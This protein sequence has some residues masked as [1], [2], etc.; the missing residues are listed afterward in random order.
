MKTIKKLMYLIFASVLSIGSIGC[1][2]NVFSSLFE[3]SN[4]SLMMLA[5]GGGGGPAA[6][7]SITSTSTNGS[8]G[9]G[10]AINVTV[11]FSRRVTLS[12]G[13]LDVTLDTGD[14]V[15]VSAPSYPARAL[16]GTYKIGRASCRERG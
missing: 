7:K 9:A 16:T 8:Y 4:K 1:N 12:V 6:I 2:G 13:T 3:D 10:A 5:L 11:N 15:S 14:V